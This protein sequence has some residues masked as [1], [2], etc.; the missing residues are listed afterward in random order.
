MDIQS[1]L[2]RYK[3]D[4]YMTE[5]FGYVIPISELEEI[6]KTFEGKPLEF[7]LDDLNQAMSQLTGLLDNLN[8]EIND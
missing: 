6:V 3:K 7:R 8:E 4:Q 1:I 5:K 2:N